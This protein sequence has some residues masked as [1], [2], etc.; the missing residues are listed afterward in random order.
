MIIEPTPLFLRHIKAL[1]KKY[2]SVWKDLEELGKKLQENPKQGE[3]LGRNCYKI[4]FAITSKN[5][6]K[7][8]NSRLIT[9]VQIEEDMIFLLAAYDKADKST[10]SDKELT[11]L[12]KQVDKE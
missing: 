1:K 5:T 8:D 2:P 7:R 10:V 3:S 4:R 6:G 9:C 11:H 12:L